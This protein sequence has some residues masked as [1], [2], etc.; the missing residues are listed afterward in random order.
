MHGARIGHRRR[1][2]HRLGKLD[3]EGSTYPY[4]RLV[5]VTKRSNLNQKQGQSNRRAVENMRLSG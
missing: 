5:S 2:R 3:Y 4:W 1:L